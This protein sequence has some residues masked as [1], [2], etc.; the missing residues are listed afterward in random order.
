MKGKELHKWLKT[1]AGLFA[2]AVRQLPAAAFA[3][4]EGYLASLG[5]MVTNAEE[6]P[7]TLG[8]SPGNRRDQG[9]LAVV[10]VPTSAK[11]ADGR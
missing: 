6:Q 3:R 4:E 7:T 11:I 10:G 9:V 8:V 2:V 5:M 1:R